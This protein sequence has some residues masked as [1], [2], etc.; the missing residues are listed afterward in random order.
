MQFKNNYLKNEPGYQKC[1]LNMGKDE[2]LDDYVKCVVAYY[3]HHA[4]R[5]YTENAARLPVHKLSCLGSRSSCDY[6]CACAKG[7]S[8]G[9]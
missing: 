8:G 3:E 7:F 4:T 6:T 1:Y 9:I 2:K 5:F